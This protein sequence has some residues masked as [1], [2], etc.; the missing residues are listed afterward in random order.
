MNNSKKKHYVVTYM[1]EAN[2]DVYILMCNNPIAFASIILSICE[3][4]NLDL[5]HYEDI[6]L[7]IEILKMQVAWN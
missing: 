2:R 5:D 1:R 4:N 6:D 7:A 3:K